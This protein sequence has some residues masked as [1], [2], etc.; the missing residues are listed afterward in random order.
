MPVIKPI[1][2]EGLKMLESQAQEYV[3]F[4]FIDAMPDLQAASMD[5]SA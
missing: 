2:A 4:G 3:D 1:D 5:C